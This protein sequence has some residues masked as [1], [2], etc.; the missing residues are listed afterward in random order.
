MIKSLNKLLPLV[1]LCLISSSLF[2]QNKALDSIL[3][4]RSLA[5]DNNTQLAQRFEY[6]RKAI[7]MSTKLSQDSTLLASKRVLSY[8]FL[9]QGD[10][11]SVFKINHENVKLAK[12]V[13][14]TFAIANAENIL[15]LYHHIYE[16]HDSAYFYYFKAVKL[17]EVLQNIKSQGEVLANMAD[18][19][20]TE[21]DY[22]GCESNAIKSIALIEQLPENDYNLETLWNANNLIAIVSAELEQYDKAL[23]YYDKTLDICNRMEDSY[24]KTLF[25]NINIAALYRRKGDYVTAERLYKKLYED[26]SILDFDPTSYSIILSGLAHAKFKNNTASAPEIKSL[27][28][29]AYQISEKEDDEVGLLSISMDMADFYFE[30]KNKDSARHYVDKAYAIGKDLVANETILEALL[31]KS[32]IETGEQATSSLN[33]Y[34][35]LSD[36]LQKAERSIRNKF[37]RIDYETDQIRA[38][39]EKVSKERFLFLLL[40]IGLF[41]TLALIYII[42]TQISKNKELTFKQQQQE[43]N[44]EIYNLMLSQQN[45]IDEARSTEK[46]RISEELHDGILGRLFGTRLSLDSLNNSNTEEAIQSRE[47]YIDELQ[48]IEQEIRKV[49]HELNTDFISNSRFIDIVK[50][51]LETQT[52]AY[53]LEYKLKNDDSIHWDAITNKTKIH[54]YRI[55]QESLQN[56]YKHAKASKV[57]ISFSIKKNVICLTITD[58]GSGFEI[59]K[60]K[61]GIGIKNITSRVKE[62]FGELKI[63][64][65]INKG[66]NITIKIPI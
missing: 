30:T 33:A 54:I 52:K 51:L 65:Q 47:S 45:K 31:L 23:E 2:A 4:L 66:T 34:I 38:E 43:T 10:Y 39:K 18:I 24:E 6:A 29:K 64:S 55:L 41:V 57:E 44:E 22:I 62:I 35:K 49:S 63:K 60:S 61:K 40:S 58:D 8:L 15:G 46:R 16:A 7:K 32:K 48:A 36:S 11:D 17:F 12:K 27:F 21:R 28:N 13:K 42:F 50:T 19:Q 1:I 20:E 59:N 53:Q 14:D 56:I 5:N 25:S 9:I 3:T 37:A 26:A